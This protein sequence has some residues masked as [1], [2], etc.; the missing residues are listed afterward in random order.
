MSGFTYIFTDGF[1]FPFG[2][3]FEMD[4]D[5]RGTTHAVW[6]EGYSYDSPARSGTARESRKPAK[7]S[8]RERTLFC[9]GAISSAR[10]LGLSSYVLD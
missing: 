7:Q 6:G 1:R 8:A 3:Y 4:V 5:E 2:D 10:L 9:D